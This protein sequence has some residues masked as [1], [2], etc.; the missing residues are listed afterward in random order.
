MRLRVDRAGTFGGLAREIDVTGAA[1]QISARSTRNAC[2]IHP[3]GFDVGGQYKFA[4]S[5]GDY[6]SYVITGTNS[7]GVL[8]SQRDRLAAIKK[9]V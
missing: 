4:Q 3:V 7:A 2:Y 5:G 8:V 6:P 1:P 9:A